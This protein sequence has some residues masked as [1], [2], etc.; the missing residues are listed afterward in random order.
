MKLLILSNNSDRAG[1]RQRIYIHMEHLRANDIACEVVQLPLNFLSRRRLFK[2]AM[3][4]D[5]VFLHKKTLNPFDSYYLKK[6][7]RKIIYDFDDAIMFD[8]KRPEKTHSKRQSSFRRTVR[9]ADLVIAGNVYLAGHAKLFNPAVEILPT[10]LDI[11]AYQLQKPALNDGKIRLVWIGSRPTMPNLKQIAPAL[12][13]IGMRFD[14]VVLRLISDEFLDLRNMK[15]EKY[16][17]TQQDEAANLVSCDIGLAPL[18]DNAFTKGKCGFKVLQYA[19]AGLP[20]VASPVGVN[21]ELVRDGINGYHAVSARDW[22]EKISSLVKNA[23]LREQMARSARQ[24][25]RSFDVSIISK[26]LVGLIKNTLGNP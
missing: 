6:Y 13:E 21:A 14:N 2:R 18:I 15:V 9:L 7:A 24:M 4:Y 22:V 25:V 20:A 12:E 17:W 3:N 8:N 5:G 10:G 23:P 16:L 11:T 19:A 26:R 1:F